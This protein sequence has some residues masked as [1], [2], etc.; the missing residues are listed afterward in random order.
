MSTKKDFS[1]EYPIPVNGKPLSTLSI[2][3]PKARDLEIMDT[4]TGDVERTIQL[5]SNLAEL[6]PDEV[7]DL[8]GEDFNKIQEYVLDCLGKS[9]SRVTRKSA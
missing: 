8:D 9:S 5:I 1:L 7:R 2:R 6:T 3:R 4:Y